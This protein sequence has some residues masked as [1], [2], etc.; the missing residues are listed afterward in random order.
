MTSI[1]TACAAFLLVTAT[2]AGVSEV[3][4]PSLSEFKATS[5][6]AAT[7]A[8]VAAG[9]AVFV[10]QDGGTPI[11]Q[12]IDIVLPQYAFHLDADTGKKERCIVIQ[13][14]EARGRRL[15]GA[16]ALPDRQLLAGFYNE[17]QLL[18][19]TSPSSSEK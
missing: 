16:Y 1:P 15:I 2:L 17:F 6:R 8:D 7:A 12:P 10:M 3:S 11:G 5:G 13:A 9:A 18:G 14:E 19:T 4:W